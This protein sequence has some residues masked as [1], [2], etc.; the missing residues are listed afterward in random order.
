MV[1]YAG[2]I[3]TYGT[4]YGAQKKAASVIITT[5]SDLAATP[6]Y[7]KV[8]QL[9]C[10]L[11]ESGITRMG[12]GYCISVSDI[13]L[14]MIV[15]YG[16]KASLMEVKLSIMDKTTGISGMIGHE[17]VWEKNSHTHVATH[18]V[19]C[20]DGEI[21]FFIDGSIAH[22]LPNNMQC[23]INRIENLG[24]KMLSNFEYANYGF[25]YQEKVDGMGIPQLHQISILERMGTDKRIFDTMKQLKLLNIIGIVLSAFALINVF[26]KV[27]LDWYN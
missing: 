22:R 8:H 1:N 15:Q 9:M 7:K 25:V 16:V 5:D 26:G 11:I 6:T 10:S 14:N 18:V 20:V 24:S 12:E 23:V 17:V 21:P 13:I 19:V 27:F 2:P 4:N 3:I